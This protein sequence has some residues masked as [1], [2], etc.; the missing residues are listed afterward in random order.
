MRAQRVFRLLLA[1]ALLWIP[2]AASATPIIYNFTSGQVTLTATLTPTT[3]PQ[4]TVLLNG[5]SS[6]TVGLTGTSVTFDSAVVPGNAIPSF[7]FVMSPFGPLTL[8]PPLGTVTT[9]SFTALSIVPGLGYSSSVA[10][11]NPYNFTAGQINVSGTVTTNIG[12][13]AFSIN[14]PSA[15]GQVNVNLSQ[16]SLNGISIWSR[17]VAGVGRLLIKGDVVFLGVPEPGL[18]VL[19]ACAGALIAARARRQ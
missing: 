6:V 9:V 4:Q 2:F 10:G 7:A 17:N 3:G 18:A 15:A 13:N 16:L 12:S 14:T 19:I 8:T 11:P 1:A 5:S